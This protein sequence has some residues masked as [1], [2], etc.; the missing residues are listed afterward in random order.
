MKRVMS[1]IGVCSYVVLLLV[2]GIGQA[3]LLANFANKN[4]NTLN[5]EMTGLEMMGYQTV[6]SLIQIAIMVNFL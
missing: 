3:M 6:L 2:I 4:N 1:F 5:Y